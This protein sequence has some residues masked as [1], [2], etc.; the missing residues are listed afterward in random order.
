MSEP[1]TPEERAQHAVRLKM[2]DD[3]WAELVAA[4]EYEEAADIHKWYW[5]V[6]F[7]RGLR[8]AQAEIERLRL[9]IRRLAEQDA[10]LSVVGGNVIVEMDATLTDAE[11]VSVKWAAQMI[12]DSGEYK[13]HAATLRGLL[14]RL[15][16]DDD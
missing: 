14:E 16:D 13:W 15:G 8:E 11:R 1:T 12:D 5:T 3:K 7:T 6:G 10:T 9:A 4:G 2:A